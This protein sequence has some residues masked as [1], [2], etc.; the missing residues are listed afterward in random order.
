MVTFSILFNSFNMS[1]FTFFI[2]TYEWKFILRIFLVGSVLLLSIKYQIK[3]FSIFL[4]LL[5]LKVKY[6]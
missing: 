3:F 2:F 4:G 6:Q 1:M 5:L